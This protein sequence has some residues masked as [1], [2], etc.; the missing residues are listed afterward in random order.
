MRCTQLAAIALTL[1][2]GVGFST[3]YAQR[4]MGDPTGIVRQGLQPEVVTLAGEVIE[5]QSGPCEKSTGR[6]LSG[7]HVLVKDTKGTTLNVHLGPTVQVAGIAENLKPG[8]KLQLQAFRTEKMEAN[9]YV[10]VVL[11]YGDQ[12]I[13]LRDESL[14]PLWAGGNRMGARAGG[15]YG[16]GR[17]GGAYG[18]QRGT[19]YGQGTQRGYGRGGNRARGSRARW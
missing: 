2:W 17:R 19:G 18:W 15:G 9:H 8:I 1:A 4:G 11:S 5:V 6:S 3:A 14:R 12:T 13:P 16:W 7:T 10:A